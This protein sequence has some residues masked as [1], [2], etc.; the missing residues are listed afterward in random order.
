MV[1]PD[2][3]AEGRIFD[4]IQDKEYDFDYRELLQ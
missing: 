4:N 2:Y 1:H 3:N